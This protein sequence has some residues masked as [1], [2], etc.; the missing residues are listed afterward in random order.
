MEYLTNNDS[1]MQ[2][3][4]R[5]LGCDLDT[6]C[7]TSEAVLAVL[8]QAQCSPREVAEVLHRLWLVHIQRR[9]QVVEP[10]TQVFENSRVNPTRLAVLETLSGQT[11]CF[12][13]VTGE[14]DR[15][16]CELCRNTVRMSAVKPHAVT[17]HFVSL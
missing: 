11:V 8:D 15:F 3:K 12:N 6:L 10:E 4:L 5:E 14:N 1:Q 9:G 16:K 2:A 17:T 7:I 13:K